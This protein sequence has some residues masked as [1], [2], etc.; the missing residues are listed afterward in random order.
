MSSVKSL[1]ILAIG[2][3]IGRTGRNYL[4][5]KIQGIKEIHKIDIVVANGENAAGG[6]SIT[7]DK[8]NELYS[9]GID[10]VTTGNHIW[11]KSEILSVIDNEEHLLR[12]ANYPDI[13]QGRGYTFFNCRGIKVCVINLQGRVQMEPID[14]PF[15][16]FDEIY[17]VIKDEADII[18]VD[19]HAEATSEKQAFGWY[20]DG[21]ASAVFG[22]HTHVQT[23]DERI[24]P[25]GTGF[26]TDVGMTGSMDSVIGM[27]KDISI[28]K[29]ITGVRVKYKVAADNPVI[30]GII[31][32][33]SKEGKTVEVLRLRI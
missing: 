13:N 2:D 29:F 5:S 32:T 4:Q 26:I 18:I 1:K 7:P 22:T 12:P 31:F 17:E 9:M 10:V 21:R 25:C 24:L 20:L 28:Q 33:I 14:N 11:D 27:D 19:F 23:S 16:K 30:N 8:L 15:K 6:I 3:I